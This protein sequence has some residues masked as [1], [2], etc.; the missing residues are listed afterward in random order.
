[1]A[2]PRALTSITHQEFTKV[3][4][5]TSSSSRFPDSDRSESNPVEKKVLFPAN[6]RGPTYPLKQKAT[7]RK[8]NP[9]QPYT[10]I[11]ENASRRMVKPPPT[12]LAPPL[13]KLSSTD[14]L[15]KR[16]PVT[17]FDTSLPAQ[18][19][20]PKRPQQS[21]LFTSFPATKSNVGKENVAPDCYSKNGSGSVQAHGRSNKTSCPSSKEVPRVSP[22]VQEKK[23][24]EQ[25]TCSSS[26]RTLFI[27][28]PEDMPT[29]KDDGNKPPYSY[30]TLI[31]MAIL[32]A[33]GRRL[34]LSQIYRW[35]SDTFVYYRNLDSGWQNS[36]RHNLSLNKAF[37]KQERPKDDP[38]KGNY[39]T[40]EV[41]QEYQFLKQKGGR[42]SSSEK[43][44]K[45]PKKSN[46][47]DPK[48]EYLEPQP[49]L[50]EQ[51]ELPPSIKSVDVNALGDNLKGHITSQEDTLLSSD[52]TEL[53]S[54]LRQ[55]LEDPFRLSSPL[56]LRD[57][58]QSSPTPILNIMHSSPPTARTAR[59]ATTPMF[60]PQSRK[61]KSSLMND[62]GYYS[63][64]EASTLRPTR[65][66][67]G[68]RIKRG[69]AEEDIARLRQS[70]YESPITKSKLTTNPSLI[71][72]GYTAQPLP[73]LTPATT[74]RLQQPPMSVSPNTNLRRHR[75][76]IKQLVPSPQ[77]DIEVL[78]DDIWSSAFPP[79][80]CDSPCSGRSDEPTQTEQRPYL[81]SPAR[82]DLRKDFRRKLLDSGILSPENA[83]AVS[84]SEMFNVVRNGFQ[85]LRDIEEKENTSPV[86]RR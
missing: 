23:T 30:A 58:Q 33:P 65:E 18:T 6:P 35:I 51:L 42:K 5:E 83:T 76:K 36:I 4:G 79:G 59:E 40:V 41:G 26:P 1:M 24:K 2:S 9:L 11:F 7:D 28:E 43:I 53:A 74:L 17:I 48:I 25:S 82:R 34:T 31:G 10:N 49:E 80:S 57:V 52:A 75:D 66:E 61:R 68:H 15:M 47:S 8:E 21:A 22:L 29:V 3:F 81:G 44:K 73:P 62:S 14:S 16:P 63:S 54:P 56:P 19:A 69:R 39:W 27:P 38:G 12:K 60:P 20:P 72:R 85:L 46:S 77:R 37:V 70:S 71:S 32:R 55:A 84:K 13:T 50:V 86:K 45:A 67:G 78:E 64:L